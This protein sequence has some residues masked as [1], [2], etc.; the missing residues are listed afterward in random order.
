MR[1]EQS[2]HA[3]QIE[4]LKKKYELLGYAVVVEPSREAIPAPLGNYRP[5]L[6]ATKPGREGGIVIEVK[7]SANKVSIDRLS[8]VAGMVRSLGPE[9]RFVLATPDDIAIPDS[10]EYLPTWRELLEKLKLVE[11]LM[12]LSDLDPAILYLYSVFEGATRAI[13]SQKAIPVERLPATRVRN[14]LYT[15][16]LLDGDD[17]QLCKRFLAMRNKVAHGFSGPRDTELVRSF[18]AFTRRIVG[19]WQQQI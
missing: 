19:E 15:L 7:N 3:Y 4:R 11:E 17:Y 10:E 12:T 18:C 9:W 13:A 16:G 8:E 1:A 5:D 14:S 6:I 2:L